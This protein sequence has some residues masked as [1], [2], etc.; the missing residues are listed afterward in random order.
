MIK[1]FFTSIFVLFSF[2]VFA[3][4][5][6]ISVD[7]FEK[8][9]ITTQNEQLID[10]RTPQEYEKA[11]IAHAKNINVRGSDFRMH[12][13]HLDK[14]KPVLVYCAAGPRSKSALEIFREA[15]FK[16]VYELN[17]GMNAWLNAEKK[18]ENN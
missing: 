13:E 1:T 17:G 2:G 6:T 4:I 8:Q 3:Q 5:Q 10:V 9:C 7:E 16:T 14:T 15:G 12:I 18:V 11:R